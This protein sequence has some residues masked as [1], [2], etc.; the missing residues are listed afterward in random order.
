MELPNLDVSVNILDMRSREAFLAS[1]HKRAGHFVG[2][3]LTNR[4]FELPPRGDVSVEPPVQMLVVY[5]DPVA[6]ETTCTF[7]EENGYSVIERVTGCDLPKRFPEKELMSG[8][9]FF[10]L[11][12]PN[13]ALLK[14]WQ[15]ILDDHI[16]SPERK[17][18]CLDLAA[19][20]GRDIIWCAREGFECVG[21]DYVERQWTKMDALTNRALS[22]L[23]E[24]EVA[25]FGS[26]RSDQSNLES[27]SIQEIIARVQ[28]VMQGQKASLLIVSRYL[29]RPMLSHLHEFVAPGGL[30]LFHTFLDGAQNVGRK[31]PT[32]ARFLLQPNELKSVFEPHFDVLEDSV[33]LLSDQRPTSCFLAKKRL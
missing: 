31:T 22:E 6:L 17:R 19:G 20:N 2:G 11:W 16:A 33:L 21:I 23:P 4:M 13:P 26:V 28:G 14:C 29:H 30:I 15:R 8:K 32:K 3:D 24:D 27:G 1:H 5:D 9:S 7:L 18:V 12:R 25:K 10:T